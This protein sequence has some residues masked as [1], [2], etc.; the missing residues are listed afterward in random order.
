ML[1]IVRAQTIAKPLYGLTPVPRVRIPLPPPASLNCKEIPPPVPAKCAKH[2]R[3]PQYFILKPDCRERTA[4]RQGGPRPAFSP[5]GTC[6]VQF[7]DEL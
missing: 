5:E 4:R 2:A 1:G 7:R 3:I 6:A